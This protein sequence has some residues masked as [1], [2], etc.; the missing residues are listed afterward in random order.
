M[1][2]RW[3]CRFSCIYS[4]GQHVDFRGARRKIYM[5]IY[6]TYNYYYR[7]IDRL[8]LHCSRYNPGYLCVYNITL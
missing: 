2:D 6:K 3:V 1:S 5:K 4:A 7:S 8:N